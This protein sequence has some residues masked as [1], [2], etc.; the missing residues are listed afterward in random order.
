MNPLF[1]VH[2]GIVI[3]VSFVYV[4]RFKLIKWWA[5]SF[6]I[7]IPEIVCGFRDDNSIVHRLESFKTLDIPKI[8]RV[9]KI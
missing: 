2:S 7:G 5:Q 9:S 3:A 6:L 4:C 1:T 8:V